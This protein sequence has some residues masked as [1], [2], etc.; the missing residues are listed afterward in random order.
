MRPGYH[1]G[2]MTLIGF[3]PAVVSIQPTGQTAGG[4]YHS[5]VS[6][7]P[8]APRR[9]TTMHWGNRPHHPGFGAKPDFFWAWEFARRRTAREL[10]Q[11]VAGAGPGSRS[12][13]P[14]VCRE[15]PRPSAP[16]S[17]RCGHAARAGCLGGSAARAEQPCTTPTLFGRPCNG[18]PARPVRV[19]RGSRPGLGPALQFFLDSSLVPRWKNFI[20]ELPPQVSPGEERGHDAPT[21]RCDALKRYGKC[22]RE[23][24]IARGSSTER[25]DRQFGQE[26]R[27]GLP[28]VVA[29]V[30]RNR[31]LG[32]R[33]LP[34]R[35]MVSQNQALRDLV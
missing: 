2:G 16:G 20:S 9:K 32:R 17:D 14:L 29:R 11:A 27:H 1:G 5:V 26:V 31:D 15:R 18:A 33:P 10:L 12:G 22:T 23:D 34:M 24:V 8:V 3:N 7:A 19:L 6:R 21:A 28:V 35:S 30:R 13:T 4:L 25:M